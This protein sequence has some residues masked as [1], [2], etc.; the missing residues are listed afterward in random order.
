MGNVAMAMTCTLAYFLIGWIVVFFIGWVDGGRTISYTMSDD[1]TLAII[2][3][4]WPLFVVA[5]TIGKI[6][7]AINAIRFMIKPLSFIGRF[8][9]GFFSFIGYIFKPYS[10]GKAIHSW[11]YY[12]KS[13]KQTGKDGSK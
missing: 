1:E 5:I 10:L 3:L 7:N 8:M 6:L 9:D 11:W 2:F 4:L 12:R 13:D